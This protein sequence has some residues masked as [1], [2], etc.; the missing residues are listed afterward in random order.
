MEIFIDSKYYSRNQFRGFL[1]FEPK[2]YLWVHAKDFGC[3][4]V[5][6]QH[7]EIGAASQHDG[8]P[9]KIF[10]ITSNHLRVGMVSSC[11]NQIHHD[12]QHPCPRQWAGTGNLSGPHPHHQP[13][14]SFLEVSQ[15]KISQTIHSSEIHRSSVKISIT[16]RNEMIPG[17][18]FQRGL[19]YGID[20]GSNKHLLGSAPAS[21]SQ[22]DSFI[23][24]S[25]QAVTLF[26]LSVTIRAS[27]MWRQVGQ[28]PSRYLFEVYFVCYFI[29]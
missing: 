24:A 3:F 26:I 22:A 21:W 8:S 25:E 19:A 15:V 4:M 17:H 5:L 1:F 18:S 27:S 9:S 13:H 7:W 14:T 16:K 2:Y 10:M 23:I 20:R 29:F 28:T 11:T 6:S 12:G